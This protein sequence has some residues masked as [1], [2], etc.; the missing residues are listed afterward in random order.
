MKNKW[1]TNSGLFANASFL[2]QNVARENWLEEKRCPEM[3]LKLIVSD[4]FDGEEEKC[5]DKRTD[6]RTWHVPNASFI[7]TCVKTHKKETVKKLKSYF[8]ETNLPYAFPSFR[9]S[10][11]DSTDTDFDDWHPLDNSWSPDR[12]N[13]NSVLWT[14]KTKGIDEAVLL[15]FWQLTFFFCFFRNRTSDLANLRRDS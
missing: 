9:I 6:S 1:C 8:K 2:F 14:W 13:S 10:S 4:E 3:R 12:Y 11:V 5:A 15:P 7:C